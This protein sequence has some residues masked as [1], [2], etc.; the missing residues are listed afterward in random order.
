MANTRFRAKTRSGDALHLLEDPFGQVFPPTDPSL[1]IP[2]ETKSLRFVEKA[3]FFY[4]FRD[5]SR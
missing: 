5:V 1:S 2:S 4:V 3:T